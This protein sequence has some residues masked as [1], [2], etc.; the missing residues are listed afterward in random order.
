MWVKLLLILLVD[1]FSF[2]SGMYIEEELLG[3]VAA[4]AK[5]IFRMAETLAHVWELHLLHI[6]TNTQYCQAFRVEI[7]TTFKE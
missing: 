7:F 3:Q 6:L 1:M 2:L 5:Q 4:T